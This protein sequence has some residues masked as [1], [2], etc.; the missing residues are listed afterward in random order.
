[1]QW[2]G[3]LG[4]D[5]IALMANYGMRVLGVLVALLVAWVIAGW[6]RR[7]MMRAF[8]K[9]KFDPTLSRFFSSLSRYTIITLSVIGCLGV[10]GVETASFAA[11]VAA[12][13][14]AIGLA[15]QNTLSNFAAGVMLLIFRPFRVGDAIIVAGITGGVVEIE[16]FTTELTTL[17]NRKIVIPNSII[18]SNPIENITGR[19]TRRCDVNVGV[20]YSADIDETRKVLEAALATIDWRIADPQSV[21]FLKGL[22][23]SSVDW[24]LR[25][26][27][28]AEDYWKTH[29]AGVRAAKIALDQ[30]GIGIPFPQ[31]DVHLDTPVVKALGGGKA[32]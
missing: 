31:M 27:C 3:K 11:I 8:E 1:M 16:L 12:M 23:A 28:K 30:A 22:G 2:I 4:T 14:L 6:V 26:W 21:V 19:E 18:F 5:T 15:F 13:G 17:D 32:A 7:A 9:A 24:Q 20:V 10:F 29:E 25:I